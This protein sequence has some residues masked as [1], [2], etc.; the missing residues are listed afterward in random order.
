MACSDHSGADTWVRFVDAS[1]LALTE[2]QEN[3]IDMAKAWS[4][5][6]EFDDTID[7][8]VVAFVFN[9]IS[10]IDGYPEGYAETLQFLKGRPSETDFIE[11]MNRE[12]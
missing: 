9:T 6:G 4:I 11:F 1:I 3:R 10:E 7:N 5:V 8:E 12:I 2:F